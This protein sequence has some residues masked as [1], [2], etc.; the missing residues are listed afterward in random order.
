MDWRRRHRWHGCQRGRSTRPSAP[1][2]WDS[3]CPVLCAWA[4]GT[5][6]AAAAAKSRGAW[7]V[8]SGW[9]PAKRKCCCKNTAFW[10]GPVFRLF[11]FIT[12]FIPCRDFG[13]LYLG[14]LTVAARAVTHSH[15]CAC[16]IFVCPNN[17]MASGVWDTTHSCV[18]VAFLCVPTMEWL[19][20]LGILLLPVCTLFLCPNNGMASSAWDTTPTSV[21]SIFVCP[22]N[23]MAS[24]AWD[25]S[26][27]HQCVCSIFVCP[28]NGMASSVRNTTH[29]YQCVQYFCVSQQ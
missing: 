1:Q 24:S 16:S 14:N 10:F 26:H 18:C 17:G 4:S 21:H 11:V 2:V 25:A 5:E 13:S 22:N 23:G 28:H 9:P 19:A 7:K 3:R 6:A 12:S 8:P 20:V 27:S 29:S 15:Q